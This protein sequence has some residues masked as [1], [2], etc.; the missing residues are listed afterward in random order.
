MITK[1]TVVVVVVGAG[2]SFDLGLPLGSV[3]QQKVVAA[4]AN[5]SSEAFRYFRAAAHNLFDKDGS[6]ADAALARAQRH[7]SG[8]RHAASVD[9]YLDQVR[10]DTDF[11]SICKMAIGYEIAKAESGSVIA[12]QTSYD[13][14]IDSASDAEYFLLDL[15]N[16]AVRGHQEENLEES[17]VNLTFIIFN[18]DRCVEKVLL[19]WLQMRFSNSAPHLFSQVK[20]VHVYG[21]LGP[22]GQIEG[23]EFFDSESSHG[24]VQN[25]HL[26][27]PDFASRIKIFTEQEDSEVAE[28]IRNA[29]HFSQ[30]IL[31]LGFGF[32]EQNMRF[33]RSP[34]S[35]AK[36]IFC[37][38]VGK[39]RQNELAI[40]KSLMEMMGVDDDIGMIG[41]KAK[42]LFS[43]FYHPIGRAVGSLP[44]T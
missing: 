18:Y 32:E 35:Y 37:T 27:I 6:R 34:Q 15:L 38:T 14:V 39:G 23:S 33:F 24:A 5:S 3:L 20:F 40:S 25:P 22:Y 7:V 28:K 43:E 42:R 17:L 44:V 29:I 11:V 36:R 10:S 2:A 8:L 9:N 30:A 4:V 41:G 26:T 12:R 31:F 19:S 21:S 13:R 1:P 16:L